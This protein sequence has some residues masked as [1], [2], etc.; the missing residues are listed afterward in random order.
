MLAH[1]RSLLSISHPNSISC[2]RTSLRPWQRLRMALMWST[3][4]AWDEALV[5]IALHGPTGNALGSVEAPA[6]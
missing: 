5:P 2:K 3:T 6:S 4:A 1:S